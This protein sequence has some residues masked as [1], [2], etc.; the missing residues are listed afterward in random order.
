MVRFRRHWRIGL[1]AILLGIGALVLPLRWQEWVQTHYAHS[2]YT[3]ESV[4]PQ[5]VAIVLGARVYANGR[6]SGMLRDRVETAVALYKA[7][8]VQKILMTGDNSIQ[9]YNEPDAMKA[10]AVALGVPAQDIQP[11]YG[12]RRTY[13]SCYRA[14]SIFEVDSAIIVTQAFHLPRALFL[15]DQLGI[16]VVGVVAD[17]RVYDPRSIAWSE[18]R[19]V[20]ATLGAL[21]DVIRRAPPPVLGDPIPL[22]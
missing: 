1:A 16:S 13:D 19:E 3:I 20:P 10:H 5:R 15:C 8:K 9:E 12:G 18:T 17:Q 11:D 4:P 6:L 7:G 21:L 2:I 22:D 14:R